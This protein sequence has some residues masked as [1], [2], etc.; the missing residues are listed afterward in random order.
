M[1]AIRR[2]EPFKNPQ[3]A[4]LIATEDEQSARLYFEGFKKELRA[5]RVVVIADHE[6][7]DPGS[8]VD[9]AKHARANRNAQVEEG[10]EDPF[11]EV[12]VVFDTE[13]PQNL[14]R[15]NA[16][17]NA[18]EQC[19]QLGFNTAVSNPS[20]EFWFL[21]HFKYHVQL[22]ANAASACRLLRKHIRGYSKN[23]DCFPILRDKLDVAV[24]HASQIVRERCAGREHP[25]D[26]H[27][28][29]QVH[30]LVKSLQ[31]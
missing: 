31:S 23:T 7:S 8:V 2:P 1:A 25:C 13:G 29:T 17:K 24:R 14:Q 27:P 30:L 4:I 10:L 6:G 18:I 11:E 22:I 21:L 15:Q 5:H 9:A 26:C 19:R 28:S 16:A 3:R 12:W 20:F